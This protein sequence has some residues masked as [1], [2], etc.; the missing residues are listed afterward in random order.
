MTAMVTSLLSDVCGVF[1]VNI[2]YCLPWFF[3][4]CPKWFW[5]LAIFGLNCNI[6][7][8]L[9]HLGNPDYLFTL[10][11]ICFC[12]FFF[13]IHASCCPVTFANVIFPAMISIP[14]C[15]DSLLQGRCSVLLTKSR[16]TKWGW[17]FHPFLPTED[18]PRLFLPSVAFSLDWCWREFFWF[19]SLMSFE[20]LTLQH[21]I[22]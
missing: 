5:Y 2:M 17:S 4:N 10:A 8:Y 15:L 22:C 6:L 18:L 11:Y 7:D 13:W 12:I 9:F 14:Q 16:R 1:L 20:K 3:H 19:C 21:Y